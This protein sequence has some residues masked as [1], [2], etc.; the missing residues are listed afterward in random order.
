LLIQRK[1]PP[2]WRVRFYTFVKQEYTRLLVGV[3]L[4]ALLGVEIY[5][6]VHR[7]QFIVLFG[8]VKRFLGKM[9][10]EI[11]NIILKENLLRYNCSAL[12]SGKDSK[13]PWQNSL[14]RVFISL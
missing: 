10:K 1:N 2:V 12:V 3:C 9:R 7:S 5:S 14:A 6:C 4:L 11:E 13:T 8:F